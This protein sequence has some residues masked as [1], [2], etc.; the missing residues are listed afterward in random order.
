[1]FKFFILQ[2]SALCRAFRTWNRWRHVVLVV[3]WFTALWKLKW[4][5]I[6]SFF[7]FQANYTVHH[8]YLTA[9]SL[10]CSFQ[11][12]CHKSSSY[13]L[14]LSVNKQFL[15]GTLSY[16]ATSFANASFQ[17]QPPEGFCKKGV[18]KNSEKLTRK[19]LCQ[20]LF[21]NKVA[22]LW[23]RCFPVN[24]AKIWRT[25]FFTE[26]LWTTASIF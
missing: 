3:V 17:K 12:T 22:R 15:L 5:V 4:T 20:S 13:E 7:F 6:S 2:I 19:H 25:Y 24:F 23:Y 18:P 26:H 14:W 21:F 16:D 1:M 10:R 11:K 8:L 9:L